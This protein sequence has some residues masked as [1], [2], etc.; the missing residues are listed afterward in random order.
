VSAPVATSASFD[1]SGRPGFDASWSFRPASGSPPG[2]SEVVVVD[3]VLVVVGIG[4]VVVVVAPPPSKRRAWTLTPLVSVPPL[5][6][7]SQTTTKP[8]APSG[9]TVGACWDPVVYVFTWDSSPTGTP[10]ASKRRAWMLRLTESLP[11]LP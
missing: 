9:A 1:F 7:L 4:T 2:T 3:E 5:P 8:P 6:A 11:V 10:A